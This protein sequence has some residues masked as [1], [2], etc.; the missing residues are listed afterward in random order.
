M[1]STRDLKALQSAMAAAVMRPLTPES[2]MQRRWADGRPAAAVVGEF[3]K[4]NDRLSA[5]ERIEIY[6]RMYWFR[7]LDCLYDDCPGLRAVLG[8]R[9][10][11]RM[12]EA[13]LVKYPSRSFTLRNLSRRLEPFIREE[14]QL[15]SPYTALAADMARFEWAQIEAF[16]GPSRPALEP[17]DIGNVHPAQLRLR[18]QPHLTLLALQYAVDDFVVAAKRGALRA[19]ASNAPVGGSAGSRPKRVVRPQRTR[20]YLAV[21]RRDNRVFFKRLDPAAY[22]LLD[23][24][25]RGETLARA[26][27]IALPRAAAASPA[28]QRRIRDWFKNWAELG[29][30]CRP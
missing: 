21:H 13:Y 28:W 29:W 15:T 9:K 26:C 18:L 22:R 14:P 8:V 16:D 30:F 12:A 5:L 19:E 2:R 1:R 24:L 7:L 10:F 3:I 17:D 23:A 25:Q 27:A 20:I 11:M 4:P 6:N